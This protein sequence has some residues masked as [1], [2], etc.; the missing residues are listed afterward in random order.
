M[1]EKFLRK[2][3]DFFEAWSVSAGAQAPLLIPD[4]PPRHDLYFN[5]ELDETR[6][7]VVMTGKARFQE[8]LTTLP[9][10]FQP[11]N[12]DTL[13]GSLPSTTSAACPACAGLLAPGLFGGTSIVDHNLTFEW[14]CCPGSA[15]RRTRVTRHAP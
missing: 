5:E 4:I 13:A 11:D 14:D 6:G 15:N 7:S 8:G 9:P 3:F 2:N 1:G 10:E 12:P